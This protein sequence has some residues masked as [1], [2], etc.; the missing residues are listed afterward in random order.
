MDRQ[1]ASPGIAC[2]ELVSLSL[3]VAGVLSF[4]RQCAAPAP[5]SVGC[6]AERRFEANNNLPSRTVD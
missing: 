6:A 1:G 3:G 2:M 5:R 4:D